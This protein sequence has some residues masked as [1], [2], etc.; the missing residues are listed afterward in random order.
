MQ[1]MKTKTF[2][3][4]LLLCSCFVFAK[5]KDKDKDEKPTFTAEEKAEFAMAQR[6]LANAVVQAQPYEFVVQQK[7]T[8]LNAIAQKLTS[9]LDPAKWKLN[10]M[11]LEPEAIPQPKAAE[12]KPESQSEEKPK[13]NPNP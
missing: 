1:S 12:V 5:D 3:V 11:T 7:Q 13:E 2:A 4:L 9:K 6:D 10:Y 8:V